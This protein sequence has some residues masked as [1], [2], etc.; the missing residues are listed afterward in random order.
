[1][2]TELC[3]GCG[4]CVNICPN[5]AIDYVEGDA[6]SR[7]AKINLEKCIDCKLCYKTCPQNNFSKL[8]LN[9]IHDS[10]LCESKCIEVIK[11][12]TSGGAFFE[13][14]S[15]II[16]N[17]GY[18][19]GVVIDDSFNVFH[20]STNNFHDLNRITKSKYAQSDTKNTF[21]EAKEKLDQGYIV[22]YSGT[23]CQIAGLKSFL[24]RDY[25]NLFTVDF[26]CHGVPSVRI[27]KD[28][29]KYLNSKNEKISNLIFR[30]KNPDL[31][32]EWVFSFVKNSKRI[33]YNYSTDAYLKAFIDSN[34]LS[35]ACYNCKY[36][37]TKRISSITVGDSWSSNQVIYKS[38]ILINDDK[39][40]LLFDEVKKNLKF[41]PIN[42][43]KV[44]E[45]RG[46]LQHPSIPKDI[47]MMNLLRNPKN[48]K[49]YFDRFYKSR[50]YKIHKIFEKLPYKIKKMIRKIRLKNE[51]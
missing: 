51:K 42:I 43:E 1:M 10:F 26:L 48:Y 36:S 2:I 12:S 4:A 41:V 47:N 11:K 25:E 5:H 32:P 34:S 29:I 8:P 24:R 44:I 14:A 33:V 27:L 19:F 9:E 21:L 15:H 50:Y 6:G 40:S 31:E 35:N 38:L 17:G 49:I 39:G 18:V 23:P 46:I 3:T 28:H 20:I 13:I 30:D 45:K 37:N 7:I 16:S 22:L